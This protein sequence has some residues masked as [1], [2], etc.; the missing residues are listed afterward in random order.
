MD[1]QQSSKQSVFGRLYIRNLI[2]VFQLS[3]AAI[4]TLDYT[5]SSYLDHRLGMIFYGLTALLA[6]H[7]FLPFIRKNIYINS[8]LGILVFYYAAAL[9]FFA[10]ITPMV[11]PYIVLLIALAFISQT[12]FGW[13]GF[14]ISMLMT[15]VIMLFSV[16]LHPEV[17]RPVELNF[18]VVIYSLLVFLSLV[19]VR[20]SEASVI[21]QK[22]IERVRNIAQLEQ[23]RLRSLI[24]SMDE[25]V[26][27]LDNDGKITLYNGAALSL[28]NTNLTLDDQPLANI[29]KLNDE[30]GKP[31]DLLEQTKKQ[32]GILRRNDIVLKIDE[33]DS[34]ILSV[35]VS[36]VRQ[37]F[38]Q[39]TG[40]GYV[41]TMRDIT[42][43]KSLDEQ[44]DDFISVTSHELRTP[45]AIVEAN[46]STALLENMQQGMQEK[47]KKLIEAAHDNIMFLANLVSD[48]T[49]LARAEK[50]FLEID[51]STVE[52]E[53]IL[54][55]MHDDYIHDAEEKNLKIEI[56][57]GK[58]LHSILTS[59]L[60]VHEIMQNFMTN[61]IK[62]SRKGTILVGADVGDNNAI[63]FWVRDTGIGISVADQKKLFSKF[64]RSEDYRTRETG[65]TGLGL[66]ISK[67]LAERMGGKIWCESE[68]NKGSTFFFE[69][70]P[71]GALK[72]D[73][74]KVTKAE[75]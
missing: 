58:K 7:A 25:A 40:E 52:P 18:L 10:F 15:L 39:Q 56:K 66:Y 69:V 9:L 67:K 22:Q 14:S 16:A 43:E 55:K 49:T 53:S 62:Y 17:I 75:I 47:T 26:I 57:P 37:S 23:D 28:L 27:A 45:I 35:S 73:H 8:K 46:L 72:T 30:E 29:M 60:Y 64:F 51:L 41:L 42:K 44:R 65:G 74:R 63:R 70:P 48:L 5:L 59:E 71:V 50:E 54:Q 31:V 34:L 68:L 20:A 61:A 11:S 36:P 32:K 3:V 33:N 12:W 21:E 1:L 4:I 6:A 2:F 38:G 19:F 24:N 13:T